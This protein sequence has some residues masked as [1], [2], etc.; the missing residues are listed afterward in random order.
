MTT[1]RSNQSGRIFQVDSKLCG[2]VCLVHT[3]Y[4]CG[5][6]VA[7]TSPRGTS[8]ESAIIIADAYC[9]KLSISVE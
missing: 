4:Y 7:E 1:I 6:I 5:I 9:D 2:T 3:L 8:L